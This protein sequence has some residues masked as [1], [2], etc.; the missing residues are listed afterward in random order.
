MQI[1]VVPQLSCITKLV[2]VNIITVEE[3]ANVPCC[4]IWNIIWRYRALQ[5]G[6]HQIFCGGFDLQYKVPQ[7]VAMSEI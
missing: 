4:Y 2:E 7:Q 6:G 5:G 1:K 3:H